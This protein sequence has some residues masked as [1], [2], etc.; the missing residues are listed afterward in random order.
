MADRQMIRDVLRFWIDEV[1]PKRWFK[2]SKALDQS[3]RDRFGEMWSQACMGD[4]DDWMESA[5]GSYALIILLDQFPRNMFRGSAD[6][7]ASDEKAL[8]VASKAIEKKFDIEMPEGVRQFFYMPFMHSEE[9]D[10]QDKCI[11]LMQERLVG[12][13]NLHHAKQHR[14][15]IRQFGRFPHR[16]KVL[17]RKTS[18]EEEAYLAENTGFGQS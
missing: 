3:I 4:F 2:S 12:E 14:D 5:E 8:K 9:L 7:F 16:N 11:S 10:A 17:G 18:Q 1:G 15:V 13:S 6:A